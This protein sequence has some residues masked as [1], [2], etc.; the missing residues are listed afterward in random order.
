MELTHSNTAKRLGVSAAVLGAA[1]K[2]LA[3]GL[4]YTVTRPHLFTENG[5]AALD[6]IFGVQKKEGWPLL[7]TGRKGRFVLCTAPD[8]VEW[9][10]E[11]RTPALYSR[12]LTVPSSRYTVSDTRPHFARQKGRSPRS[13]GR[14]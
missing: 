2:N 5:I 1:K 14:W 8:G 9:Q 7:V 12:G 3:P 10:L 11:V 6:L 4:H 13:R